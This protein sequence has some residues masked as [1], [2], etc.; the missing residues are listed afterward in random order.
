MK[1]NRIDMM[2]KGLFGMLFLLLAGWA[3]VMCFYHLGEAG[4]RNWDESR[5]IVNAYEMLKTNAGWIHTFRYEPDYFNFK[6]PLSMWSIILCFKLFGINTFTM[7]LASA[8]SMMLLFVLL[9]LFVAKSYGKRAAVITGIV[10]LSGT[11]LFFSHMARNGDADA[12]Y[13]LMF[14]AAMI[15]L[16]LSE[17]KPWF[18]AGTGVFLSLAFMAKCL[19]MALGL[20]IVI[21]YLPRIYKK[22]KLKHY[23][24]AIAGGI[25]PTGIW[26]VLRFSYDG[27]TFFSGMFINEVAN[28]VADGKDY[29]AYV[30]YFGK[31][32][33]ILLNLIAIL[34]SVIIAGFVIKKEKEHL[35]FKDICWKFVNCRYY[36]YVLWLVIPFIVYSVSGSF[37]RWYSYVCYLPFCVIAGLALGKISTQKGKFALPAAAFILMSVIGLVISITDSVERMKT[38]DSMYNTDIRK[39]LASLVEDYP[40]YVGSKIYIENS[41]NEHKAQNEWE[42]SCIADAY[43]QGDFYPIDGGVPLFIEDEDAILIISKDLFETYSNVLTGRI[44][45][46]DGSGYLVFTNEFYS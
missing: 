15:C 27:F 35:S 13:L 17:K 16:Y 19:H 20:V 1:E 41:R 23:L 9:D 18:L 42:Q 44:I 33:V 3:G 12:L 11:D 37:L 5:H 32:P 14:T 43:I 22:L 24:A 38:L 25:I 30:R 7:R 10:F 28:R 46:V 2:K 34:A 45:L 21:C 40:E 8:V 29:L 6:P 31:N 39:D 26:A 4:T 36:L